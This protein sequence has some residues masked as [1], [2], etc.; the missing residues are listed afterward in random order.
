ME[1]LRTNVSHLS[2]IFVLD[3]V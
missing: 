2:R 3:K 1:L